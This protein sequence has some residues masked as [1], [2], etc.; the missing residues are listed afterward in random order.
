[1]GVTKRTSTNFQQIGDNTSRWP[2]LRL[3]IIGVIEFNMFGIPHIGAD[4]CGFAGC[5]LYFCNTFVLYFVKIV[6]KVAHST[7]NLQYFLR[8]KILICAF[9]KYKIRKRNQ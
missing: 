3:S 1:M 2:D 9:L 6:F 7:L 5:L 8:L 4:I